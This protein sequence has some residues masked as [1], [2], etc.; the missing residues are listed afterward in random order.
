M[1]YFLSVC[2]LFSFANASV[3]VFKEKAVCALITSEKIEGLSDKCLKYINDFE[4][5]EKEKN[6]FDSLSDGPEKKQL[7][8]SYVI[9]YRKM[10]NIAE[11]MHSSVNSYIVSNYKTNDTNTLKNIDTIFSD[12]NYIPS[13]YIMQKF[14]DDSGGN[15]N[16]SPAGL[17][18]IKVYINRVA[19]EQKALEE[20]NRQKHRTTTKVATQ[21]ARTNTRT[22]SG[23]TLQESNNP[24]LQSVDKISMSA[25]YTKVDNTLQVNFFYTNKA[26]DKQ[27]Y[28]ENAN[29]SVSASCYVY[30]E[31]GDWRNSKKGAQIG[32]NVG[33]VLDRAF[34][35]LYITTS[36]TRYKNGIVECQ[37]TLNGKR[38]NTDDTFLFDY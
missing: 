11:D 28:W 1:K 34:Q 16:I 14:I 2:V 32:S 30:E 25:S 17:E 12:K 6:K 27:V 33:K 9:Q 7:F 21:Q 22:S 26:T 37:L 5:F 4:S 10:V 24:L 8:K 36:S 13:D 19:E 29:G 38:F 23:Y 18:K 15:V 31:R 20:I 35:N 3:D